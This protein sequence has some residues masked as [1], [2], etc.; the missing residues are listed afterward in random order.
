MA[1]GKRK[2]STETLA[3]MIKLRNEMLKE[4]RME[5]VIKSEYSYTEIMTFIKGEA[6]EE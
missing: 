5:A 1:C 4:E 2:V 3:D 6:V